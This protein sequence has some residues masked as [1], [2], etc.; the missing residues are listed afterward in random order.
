MSYVFRACVLSSVE[1]D[2][3]QSPF[4][5]QSYSLVPVSVKLYTLTLRLCNVCMYL[6]TFP[7]CANVGVLEASYLFAYSCRG[8]VLRTSVN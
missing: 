1:F 2:I 4:R 5:I 7:C 6:N 3:F 8:V